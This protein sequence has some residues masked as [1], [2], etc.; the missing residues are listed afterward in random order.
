MLYFDV[1]A[2]AQPHPEADKVYREALERH[3]HNPSSPYAVGARAHLMLDHA[4]EELAHLLG[5]DPKTLVFN[6]GATEGN[7]SLFAW[8]HEISPE[9]KV[10]VS[11]IEHPCVLESAR[12]YFPR[13]TL[14][15]PVNSDGVLELG[16]LEGALKAGGLAMVSVMAANNETGALQPWKDAQRLCREYGVPFHCDAVQW[17]GKKSARGLGNCDFLT[18][19]AHKFG[20]PRGAGFLKVPD[21]SGYLGQSGG[22]QEAGR[23]SGTENYPAVA[24]MMAALKFREHA[25]EKNAAEWALHRGAFELTLKNELGAQV[26]CEKTPRLANTSCLLMPVESGARWVA[27]MDKHGVC[28]STGSACASGKTGASHVLTAMGL[29][30]DVARRSVRVSAGW[31]TR[32]QDWTTLADLLLR[33]GESFREEAASAGKA[34]VIRI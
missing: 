3:W 27:R 7:H 11:A 30:P 10:A 31:E 26:L 8:L 14:L 22:G 2:T 32:P 12:R 25:V 13:G 20:G 19:C 33:T 34:Q 29:D 28:L 5:C 4:R 1:N 21:G 18:G 6:S 9:S 23:R 17:L 15:L 24:A 16:A